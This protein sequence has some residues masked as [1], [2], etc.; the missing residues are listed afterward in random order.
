MTAMLSVLM[1]ALLTACG[2]GTSPTASERPVRVPNGDVSA[3]GGAKPSPKDVRRQ[4]RGDVAIDMP[5][6]SE[7][8]VVDRTR[9][10][11][12]HQSVGMNILGGIA[13]IYADEGVP[14]PEIEEVDGT[15]GAA[16]GGGVIEHAFIGVNGDPVGKMKAFVRLMDSP[17]AEKIDV[18]LM[19]LCY[20]DFD[21]HV[22][23]RALFEAYA[24]T[25]AELE[26]QHPA[27]TFLYTTAPLTTAAF[28]ADSGS[29]PADN[30]V[31]EQFNDMVRKA[32]GNSGRLVD[33]G[34]IEST[35]RAG[36]LT[37]S[38]DG[39]TYYVLDDGLSTDGGHLNE[40]G[41]EAVAAQFLKVV[42]ANSPA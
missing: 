37:G 16:A 21:Q 41:S 40:F 6:E 19:K 20:V 2:A 18:A 24:T 31:R 32:Y 10:L 36:R 17:A 28:D 11:F 15:A 8:A 13:S 34:A 33:I 42:A 1:I 12:G 38:I 5:S 9:V 35:T 23:P 4:V 30:F 7:L 27:V 39:H 26:A 29:S 22:D 3:T 14:P 25:M